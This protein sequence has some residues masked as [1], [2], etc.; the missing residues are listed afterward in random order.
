MS[1][2]KAP[3]KK[4]RRRR[5]TARAAAP[6]AAN[7]RLPATVSRP[8]LLEKDSDDRFRR[9]VY[10]LLTIASRMTTVR[11]HLGS[12]M[13]ISAP[14]YSLLMAVGQF[15]GERGVGVTAVAEVLHVSSAFV[16]TESGKLALAGLLAK[17]ANPK[18]GRAV[19]LSLTRAGRSLIARHS[20]EIRAVNDIF[21]GTLTP[22]MF[23][24]ASGAMAALVRGSA[25]ATAS[26]HRPELESELEAGLKSWREA[27]E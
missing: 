18:D 2:S 11:E 13:G 27:A 21:F 10:D 5:N 15:Q 14:Q 4:R 9:L 23:A 7:A 20:A 17:R 26:L 22:S 6:E 12:R 25:R 19:L 1:I 16:A 3:G 8:A 24:A